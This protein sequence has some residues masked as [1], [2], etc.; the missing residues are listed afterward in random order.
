MEQK[1]KIKRKKISEKERFFNLISQLSSISDQYSE[2]NLRD[3]IYKE[4]KS[5]VELENIIPKD[6]KKLLEIKRKEEKQKRENEKKER[7][8]INKLKT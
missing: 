4:I 5:Y 1:Q 2:S 7:Q 3:F 6:E 8:K